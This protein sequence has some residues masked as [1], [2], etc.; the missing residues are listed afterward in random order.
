MGA[1]WNGRGGTRATRRRGYYNKPMDDGFDDGDGVEFGWKSW[2]AVT[3][4]VVAG[5]FYLN[6]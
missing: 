6:C 3:I 2:L 1:T 5:L 4:I